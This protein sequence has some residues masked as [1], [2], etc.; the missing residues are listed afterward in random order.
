MYSWN[1]NKEE[2]ANLKIILIM[3]LASKRRV[4][5]ISLTSIFY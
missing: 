3:P 4:P 1:D 5:W 2:Y